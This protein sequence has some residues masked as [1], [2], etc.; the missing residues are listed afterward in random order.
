MNML[1]LTGN[2]IDTLKREC[3]L[4]LQSVRN[5]NKQWF[6]GEVKDAIYAKNLV[7]NKFIMSKSTEDWEIYMNKRNV[8]LQTIRKAQINVKTLKKV[9][10]TKSN[11]Y[12][13]LLL[14]LTEL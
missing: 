3:P 1:E 2:M 6:N 4:M 13:S 7:H 5:V 12:I 11:D 10:S 9:I 8:C 14:L